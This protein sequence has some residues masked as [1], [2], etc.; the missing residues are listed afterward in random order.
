MIKTSY[1]PEPVLEH[2]VAY[3]RSNIWSLILLIGVL[4]EIQLSIHHETPVNGFW[5]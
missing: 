3:L 2:E 4:K 5:A 1:H